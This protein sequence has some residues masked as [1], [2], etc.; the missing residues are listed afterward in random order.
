MQKTQNN[1]SNENISFSPRFHIK[2][3]FLLIIITIKNIIFFKEIK[4][5]LVLI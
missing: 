4:F 5:L 1:Y 3:E 2:V